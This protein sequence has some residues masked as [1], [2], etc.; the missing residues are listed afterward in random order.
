MERFDVF[1]VGGGGTGS[2]IAFT[3]GRHG[4]MR[5][6][7]AERD[8]LGGECNHYGCVPTKV[9][10]RSA[11][12]A[13][14]ARDAGRFGVH[15]GS[16]SVDFAAVIARARAIIDA[17]SG[18]GAAPFE[19]MG[20]TVLMDQVR[21]IAPK[22][23][24]V[25]DGTRIHADKIVL[26]TG[27]DASAPPIP[28]LADGPFW[29]NKEAIWS[30]TRPPAHLVV[31]GSGPI[32]IEFAQIYR[33]FGSTVTVLEA[34]D[35]IVP[36]EDEDSGVALRAALEEEGI[37]FL[38]GV[39]ITRAAHSGTSWSL[40]IEG[41]ADLAADEV[42]VATGRAPRF[43][44][45]DLEAVGLQ[46]EKGKPV[47]TDTLRTTA[48]DI[49]AAGDATG[50]LLF[51][52]VGGYEAELVVKDILGHPESR[53][54]RVIPKVT[55]CDP[56]V[57][58]VGMTEQ[59]ARDTGID[60]ATSLRKFSDNERA[61]IEGRTH[62]HVKLVANARTG[63]LLGGHMVGE[64]AGDMIHEIVAAM[65]TRGSVTSLGAAIHAYPTLSETV[66]GAFLN[67]TD[68]LG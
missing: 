28:G 61:Q 13:A 16:V 41:H 25:S 46:L 57:A 68:S 35:R 56:E 19:R 7:L 64:G 44:D 49:W 22:T 24:E 34:V 36:A 65:A 32:G 18:E 42:L 6:G 23:L 5:V 66:R 55:Y 54:Y 15:T 31:I 62:G 12:I 47:L 53:D 52:H 11:K 43:A 39:K 26:A 17:S 1:V 8:K 45:H 10:L 38:T 33:R 67:L 21:V 4:G 37:T 51:T 40:S 29:T 3:L 60:V 20:I 59:A 2:E 14:I 48:P 30:P 27:T 9:M 58:S 50:E 63:E